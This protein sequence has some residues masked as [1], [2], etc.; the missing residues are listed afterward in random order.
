MRD[1]GGD[2]KARTTCLPAGWARCWWGAGVRDSGPREGP[3]G[4]GRCRR[5]PEGRRLAPRVGAGRLR[6]FPSPPASSLSSVFGHISFR[7]DWELVKVDFRPSFPRQ[8]SE[9]DYGSW[10][11]SDLKVG[12]GAGGEGPLCLATPPA[13]TAPGTR[14][15]G[16]LPRTPAAPDV[17]SFCRVLRPPRGAR[18]APGLGLQPGSGVPQAP[19]PLRSPCAWDPGAV[20]RWEGNTVPASC[21]TQRPTGAWGSPTP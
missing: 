19:T 2:T 1:G 8:C 6:S 18:A 17:Q 3:A 12:R 5:G 21:I 20:V 11:L 13:G 15:A 10:H 4:A 7:S 9:D 16:R 14:P